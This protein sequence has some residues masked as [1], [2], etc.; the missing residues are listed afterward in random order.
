[1]IL[2][3]RFSVRVPMLRR[4]QVDKTRTQGSGRIN[5]P[6]LLLLLLLSAGTASAGT[7]QTLC[8]FDEPTT[9][10]RR[11]YAGV[12]STAKGFLYGTTFQGGAG[13]G[14]TVFKLKS[15]GSSYSVLHLF[16]TNPPE[17]QSPNGL[18]LASDGALYGT[19][20][21]GGQKKAGTVYRIDPD[22][23]TYAAL[24]QFGA[25][26]GDGQ[27]PQAEL[28]EGKDGRLYGTTFFGGSGDMGT[29]FGLNKDGSGFQVLNNFTG[30]NGDGGNPDTGLV[31]GSDGFLYGTTFFGGTDDLGTVFKVK[32]DGT[33]YAILHS[34]SKIGSD[35]NNPDA[36]LAQASD[37]ALYGTTAAGGTAKSG[38][39][40]KLNRDGSAYVVL[41]SFSN[42]NSDGQ[43]PLAPLL[44]GA[45][46]TLY[47]TTYLGGS[48]G[49]GTLFQINQDGSGYQ[50]VQSFD[51]SNGA[52][53]NPRGAL[54][55]GGSGELYGSTWAGGSQGFGIVFRL[56]PAAAP[57]VQMGR[58]SAAE[59]EVEISGEAGLQYQVQRSTDLKTWQTVETVTMPP[60]GN[61]LHRDSPIPG[62]AACYRVAQSP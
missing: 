35:G 51:R 38:T 13:S 39:I 54:A 4:Q 5:S 7:L 42:S 36:A 31:Q 56:A 21:I 22:G 24:H 62:P 14:G 11:P 45:G 12:L 19:T 58:V 48:N 52:G 60:S 32:T 61:H 20:A 18:I 44:Q 55:L 33:G 8:T 17:G 10:G 37:G 3:T 47:G 29:V 59:V 25:T 6:T 30:F 41:H 23:T 40:Y 9:P 43:K 27:N 1:M 34:F 53:Q 16:S 2:R 50:L 26:P 49:S 15:D 57:G 28:V 46:G